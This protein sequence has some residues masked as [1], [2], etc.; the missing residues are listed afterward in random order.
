MRFLSLLF[1]MVELLYSAPALS[2]VRDFRQSDGSTFQA[3]A[4]G[5]QYLNWIETKDGDIL[6]YNENSR[7]FEYATIKDSSL[8]PSG[9]R[10]T[11][12]RYRDSVSIKKIDKN[13]LYKLWMK[14]K[15]ESNL[16]RFSKE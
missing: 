14:K 13:E 16:K 15:R 2:V 10:Y 1:L 4:Q 8:K 6:R 7:D 11:Q 3:K 5:D 12:K 9:S